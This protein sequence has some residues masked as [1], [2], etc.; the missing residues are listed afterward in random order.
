MKDLL[1]LDMSVVYCHLI[2]RKELG[3]FPRMA[4][5]V[6][7]SDMSEPYSERGF[8][9]AN[10][11]MTPRRT[12]MKSKM[13]ECL[14]V[15]RMNREFM[16]FVRETYPNMARQTSEFCDSRLA[17]EAPSRDENEDEYEDDDEG[18]VFNVY[19][20]SNPSSSH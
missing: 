20:E 17:A 4:L 10:I 3:I 12:R 14:T 13:L 7:G 2:Q 16:E 19:D 5:C 15:L 1:H 11:I 9:A 8:S 6:L 18:A